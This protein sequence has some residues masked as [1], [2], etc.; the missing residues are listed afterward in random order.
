[1]SLPGRILGLDIGHVRIGV[2]MSDPMRILASP[3]SVIQCKGAEADAAAIAHLVKEHEVT[4]IV[5]GLPLNQHGDEGPQAAKVREFLDVLKEHVEVEIFT[6]DERFTSALA[7]RA[8]ISADMRRNKR[9]KVI[10][11]VAAQQILQVYLDRQKR[12]RE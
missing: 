2:A 9:K 6:L 10:D 8:L 5:A 11:K 4:W 7:E 3:H 1:V 12:L